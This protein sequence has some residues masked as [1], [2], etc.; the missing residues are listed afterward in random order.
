MDL[1]LNEGQRLLAESARQLFER[2]YTTESAR[3]AE[4]APEGSSIELWKQ[5]C[6]LGWPGIALPEACGGAGYGV[7]ELCVLA[8]ELGRG[9]ATLPLLSSYAATLPLVWSGSDEVRERWL[10][11]LATGDAIAAL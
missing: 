3:A 1:T 5:A 6:E 11:P 2:S 9:A 10:A 4:A 7:L 8:E